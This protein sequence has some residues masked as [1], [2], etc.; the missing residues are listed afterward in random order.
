MLFLNWD[1]LIRFFTLFID[2]KKQ[3]VE[4]MIDEFKMITINRYSKWNEE[5]DCAFFNNKYLKLFLV[6]AD[7]EII[8]MNII[9]VIEKEQIK[10]P[11]LSF[12]WVTRWMFH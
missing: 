6:F 1:D 2:D 3:G 9:D 10:K 5:Y 12:Q 7:W 8:V 11:Y 4:T